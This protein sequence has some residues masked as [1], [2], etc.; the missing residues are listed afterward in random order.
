MEKDILHQEVKDLILLGDRVDGM[1]K[2]TDQLLAVHIVAR[3]AKN[4]DIAL[5][6]ATTA[7][8]LLYLFG[9]ECQALI[10]LYQSEP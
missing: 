5:K 7:R 4:G 1:K 10:R 3:K 8:N 2:V 9:I 6:A